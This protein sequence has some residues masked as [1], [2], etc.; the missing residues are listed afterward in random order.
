[1]PDDLLIEHARLIDGTGAPPRNGVAILI[2]EGRVAALGTAAAAERTRI[3]DATGMSVLPG[4][5]DSHV[6]FV[7]APGSAYRN[8]SDAAIR[9]L[10]HRHLAAYLACGVTT[11]LDAGAFPEVVRDIQEWLRAGNAGPRYLTTGPYI[12]PVMATILIRASDGGI[13]S[14]PAHHAA[15]R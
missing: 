2:H 7:K 11:V 8:D 3:I 4:L 15:R 12:R 9:D 5:I 1:M 6:H 13:L 14:A 10:N